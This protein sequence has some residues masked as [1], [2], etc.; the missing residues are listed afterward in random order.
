MTPSWQQLSQTL[1]YT[2]RGR[3]DPAAFAFVL[4]LSVLLHFTFISAQEMTSTSLSAA[5][6]RKCGAT[7]NVKHT[8]VMFIISPAIHSS[9]CFHVMEYIT[10]ITCGAKSS[11]QF[12]SKKEPFGGNLNDPSF[13]GNGYF[14]GRRTPSKGAFQAGVCAS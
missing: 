1:P 10:P 5:R 9:Y 4:R 12:S 2:A 11:E 8:R 6:A 7:R 14:V 3:K 13:S